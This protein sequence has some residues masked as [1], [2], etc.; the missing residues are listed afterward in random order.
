MRLVMYADTSFLSWPKLTASR[1]V[2]GTRARVRLFT[3][4]VA[5]LRLHQR[6]RSR[7]RGSFRSLKGE[8][9]R[10]ERPLGVFEGRS[11]EDVTSGKGRCE[12]LMHEV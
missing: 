1:E 7:K 6:S 8:A 4:G 2:T 11:G 9:E 3:V 12:L 10:E 5:F